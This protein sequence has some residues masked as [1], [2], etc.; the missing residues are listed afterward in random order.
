MFLNTVL[1]YV[2]CQLFSLRLYLFFH[3]LGV[4]FTVISTILKI[5]KRLFNMN[6]ST[7][8]DAVNLNN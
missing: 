6:S 5:R 3:Y 4:R 2:N 8:S 7:Y 1:P